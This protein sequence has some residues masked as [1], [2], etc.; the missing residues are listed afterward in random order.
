[1]KLIKFVGHGKV[2]HS[3]DCKN[4]LNTARY[5]KKIGSGVVG[6]DE[7]SVYHFDSNGKEYSVCSNVTPNWSKAKCN[8]IVQNTL[9]TTCYLRTSYVLFESHIEVGSGG[10]ELF[11]W[12][13]NKYPQDRILSN[14]YEPEIYEAHIIVFKELNNVQIDAH[15]FLSGRLLM[16][17]APTT[18]HI[19]IDQLK[20]EACS[21]FKFIHELL[22]L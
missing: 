13:L 2:G 11:H 18:Q 20:N 12:N 21:L 9:R 3:F 6:Q 7:D 1:M 16:K 10:P 8:K 15:M 14:I 22:V 17:C 4:I 19:S 5:S